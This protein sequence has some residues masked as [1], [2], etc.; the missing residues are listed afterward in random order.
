MKFILNDEKLIIE[1]L[2]KQIVSG[3]IGYYEAEVEFNDSWKDLNIIA[4]FIRHNENVGEEKPV[5]LNK[6]QYDM[7]LDGTY[8][9]GFVGYRLNNNNE[10]EYQI[11]TTLKLI[12]FTKGAGQIKTIEKEI[13]PNNEWEQYISQ[14][15]GLLKETAANSGKVDDVLVDGKSVVVDKIA[16]IDLSSV[17]DLEKVLK[18]ILEAIQ[19]GGTTSNTIAEIEQIIVSYF[20][21]KTVSEVEE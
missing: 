5:F 9:I 6:L 2:N 13:P 18:D 15:Q 3:T 19:E 4:T 11:S 10:K 20:E 7:D 17:S 12:T 21:N 1:N 14:I 16:N 8:L